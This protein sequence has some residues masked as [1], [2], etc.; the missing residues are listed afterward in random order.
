MAIAAGMSGIHP[1]AVPVNV[2][3]NDTLDAD[4]P[5]APAY[6]GVTMTRTS[7]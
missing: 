2:L 3:A 4:H 6:L 1:G 7:M 5:A